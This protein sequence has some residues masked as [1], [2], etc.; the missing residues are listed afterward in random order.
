MVMRVLEFDLRRV[1]AG[2]KRKESD[3]QKDLAELRNV[4]L[5]CCIHR[6]SLYNEISAL[7]HH[8]LDISLIH[9][10]NDWKSVMGESCQAYLEETSAKSRVEM[11]KDM[12]FLDKI[13]S[14]DVAHRPKIRS[15]L[16]KFRSQIQKDLNIYNEIKK[17]KEAHWERERLR[18]IDLLQFV[19]DQVMDRPHVYNRVIAELQKLQ[20]ELIFQ[21]LRGSRDRTT[22]TSRRFRNQRSMGTSR[23]KGLK[24][25]SE[26]C[27]WKQE[28]IPSS[29]TR[30]R[31]VEVLDHILDSVPDS[32]LYLREL[33]TELKEQCLNE[34]RKLQNIE[35]GTQ[36]S[37]HAIITH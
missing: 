11:E 22:F 9:N 7:T 29:A 35:L 33:L 1:W 14:S 16:Q 6:P 25:H 31:D 21:E 30:W 17:A 4:I 34:A 36:N 37:G 26:P 28:D 18:D 3:L 2:Q 27:R 8:M 20:H 12:A 23:R 13:L 24:L 15:Y 19:V 5:P 32:K 10:K